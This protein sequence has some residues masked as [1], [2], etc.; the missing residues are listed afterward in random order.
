[1]GETQSF[2]LM[3]IFTISSGTH[4]SF[5]SYNTLS[6]CSMWFVSEDFDI[7]GQRLRFQQLLGFVATDLRGFQMHPKCEHREEGVK[8]GTYTYTVGIFLQS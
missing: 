8:N 4:T 7:G 2:H 6:L 1:M 3:T 5:D